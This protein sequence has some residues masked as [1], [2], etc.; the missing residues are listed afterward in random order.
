MTKQ[1]IIDAES[2]LPNGLLVGKKR[3]KK[4]LSPTAK[5]NIKQRALS[6]IGK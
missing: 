3:T 6:I 1:E 5:E 2:K 4:P